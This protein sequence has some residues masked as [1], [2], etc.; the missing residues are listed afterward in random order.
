MPVYH[1]DAH[2]F[3]TDSFY[4][5]NLFKFIPSV[6]NR[7]EKTSHDIAHFTKGSFAST[8]NVSHQLTP[9]HVME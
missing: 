4:D 5:W 1:S 6:F 3:D 7:K 8:T 9:L 2:D